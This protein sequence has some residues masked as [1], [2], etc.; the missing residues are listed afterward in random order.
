[1]NHIRTSQLPNH[2]IY[3][4]GEQFGVVALITSLD[5]QAKPQSSNLQRS[6]ASLRSTKEEREMNES[7]L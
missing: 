7:L 6:Y 2:L 5:R 4:I 1:M 3:K